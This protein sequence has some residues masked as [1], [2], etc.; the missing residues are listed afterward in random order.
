MKPLPF[1]VAKTSEHAIAVQ[2]DRLPYFYDRLHYH[3]EWQITLIVNSEGML[4][5][6]DGMCR[7]QAGDVFCVGSNLPHLFRNDSKYYQGEADYAEAIS[8][9]FDQ[10]SFGLGFFDIP[11]LRE[12]KSLLWEANKGI[13]FSADCLHGP[14]QALFLSIKS[15]E[16]L[17]RL[18][19]FLSLLEQLCR[20]KQGQTISSMS[21]DRSRAEAAGKRLDEVLQF[22]FQNYQK[23]ITVE[24]AAQTCNLSVPAFCRYFKLHTRKTFVAYVNEVRVNAAC[25]LLID[26]HYSIGQIAYQVGFNNLSNF[27]R[28]FKKVKGMVPSSFQQHYR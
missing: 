9:F 17:P 7:F 14:L 25:Q 10:N 8:V 28:Q 3:P 2:H 20:S 22:I 12:A 27:N 13:Y 11:E 4:Y 24:E 19:D 21:Y 5:A 18:Q 23:K 26:Q 15:Q 6:G 1:K 16:G